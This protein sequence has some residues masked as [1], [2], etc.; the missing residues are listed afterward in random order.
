MTKMRF[1]KA[2]TRLPGES[3]AAGITTAGL[4][5]PDLSCA[6]E[7]HAAYCKALTQCG[8]QVTILEADAR[9]PDSTFVEDTA[10]LTP[11]VAVI[12]HP[13]ADSRRGETETIRVALKGHYGEMCT[14]EAPGT[15]DGGD[16]CQAGDHFFIGVSARTNPEGARQLAAFLQAAGFTTSEIDIRGTSGLLHLKSGMSY[17]GNGTMLV[18]PVLAELLDFDGYRVL[19]VPE[20]ECY[21]ANCIRVNDFVLF[22]KGYPQTVAMLA[23][24]GFDLM[25]LDMSEFRK[26]DGGLSCLSLRF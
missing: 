25:L 18:D 13:G 4:G 15:V 10:V 21:A 23:A 19:Q 8:V 11:Q 6:L 16:I 3:F 20:D 5:A 1:S 7:Q 26:M 14:I 12:T 24:E 22:A 17:L 9:F 2:I